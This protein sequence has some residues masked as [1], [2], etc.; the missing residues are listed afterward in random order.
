[1]ANKNDEFLKKLLATFRVEANEHLEAMSAGLIE[2]EKAPAGVRW[3]ELM[4]SIYREAHSLKGAARAVNFGE[5]ESVCHALE[6]VFG[7]LKNNRV[8]PSVP[9]FDLLQRTLDVLGGLLAS[10]AQAR[11]GA[12]KQAVAALIR[13][14]D[15]AIEQATPAR[16]EPSSVPPPGETVLAPPPFP[17][18]AE[19]AATAGT[20]AAPSAGSGTIRVYTAKLDAVMRQTEELFAP[21]LAAGQRVQEVRE[22]AATLAAWKRQ[23]TK[24]QPA[25]R[26][27][28]RSLARQ[29]K[30]NGAARG[31]GDLTKLLEYLEAENLLLKTVE[32]R[33]AKLGRSAEQDHR[34]MTGMVDSLLHDVKEMHLMPFSSLL[35]LLPRLARELARDQGKLL[36]L[37]IRGGRDRDRPSHP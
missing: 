27:I 31:Q 6:S 25:L 11:P 7:G 16:M 3:S 30:T 15:D 18:K 35:D 21:R 19:P 20:A 32:G 28:E 17:A 36:E 5:I 13:Q 1:M 37:V 8:A 29:G 2:L 10:D 22:T 33:L 26:S 23:R 34:A 9:L 14:L 4:E 24:V 12:Q